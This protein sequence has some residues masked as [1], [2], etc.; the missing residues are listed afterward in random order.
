MQFQ[1]AILPG[2][3]THTSLGGVF[4]ETT[5][6]ATATSPAGK[7][8]DDAIAFL[9]DSFILRFKFEKT[10]SRQLDFSRVR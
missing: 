3:A 7:I 5:V 6:C 1:E 2:S 9:I 8:R 4:S 10:P